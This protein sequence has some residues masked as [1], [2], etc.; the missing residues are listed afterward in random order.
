MLDRNDII[1]R[2][3]L[4]EKSTDLRKKLNKYLFEVSKLVNKTEAKKT[5]EKMFNVKVIKCNILNEK[6]KM[7][8]R[9]MSVGF[10]NDWKKIIVTLAKGQKIEF[11]E[12]F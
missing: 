4:T 12:G 6:G 1:I 3:I 7:K 11:F 5:I 10:Q 2:P 9:R 8:R